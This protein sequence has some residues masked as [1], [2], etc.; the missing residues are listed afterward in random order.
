MTGSLHLISLFAAPELFS[1]QGDEIHLKDGRSS[2]CYF[3]SEG[4]SMIR[5][6]PKHFQNKLLTPTF[7]LSGV[8]IF[9]SAGGAAAQTSKTSGPEQSAETKTRQRRSTT[10]EPRDEDEATVVER[11]ASPHPGRRV[12]VR[13]TSLLVR[14]AVVEDKL[15]KQPEFH[16]GI[17]A[18][19]RDPYDADLI[20]EL[21]H[22]LFTKYVFSVIDTRTQ[23]VVAS[24]KL[25]SIGGTVGGKVARAFVK[26][27]SRTTGP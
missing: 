21:R 1:P 11:P 9:V 10:V 26:E 4:L 20:L 24:R 12:F 22:D 25:S 19:T 5:S 3:R 14:A 17:F 15:L 8:I 2:D 7:I 27:M 6:N 18:L 16:Q 23:L 13:S